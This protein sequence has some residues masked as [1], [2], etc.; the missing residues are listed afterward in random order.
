MPP[1]LIR[2]RC[3]V[4]TKRCE[5]R[6][7]GSPGLFAHT[8]KA[9]AFAIALVSKTKMRL[10]GKLS[11]ISVNLCALPDY[12]LRLMQFRSSKDD[13]SRFVA[14]SSAAPSQIRGS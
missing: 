1:A 4:V 7:F 10:S 11:R 9:A 8:Q 13:S 3:P 12:A 6:W 2:F 14:D 5:I